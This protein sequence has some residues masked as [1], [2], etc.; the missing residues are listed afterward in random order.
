MKL[1]LSPI[2][3]QGRTCPGLGPNSGLWSR[4]A[5]PEVTSPGGHLLAHVDTSLWD[6]HTAT[7]GVRFTAGT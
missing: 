2:K 5:V 6:T 1:K 4:S 3:I 7:A